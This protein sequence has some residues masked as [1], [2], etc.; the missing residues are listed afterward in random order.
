LYKEALYVHVYPSE[1]PHVGNITQ[2]SM[3][4][5]DTSKQF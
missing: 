2:H 5:T 4:Q 3:I 1:M